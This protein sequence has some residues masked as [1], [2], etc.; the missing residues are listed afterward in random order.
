MSESFG[1]FFIANSQSG[2]QVGPNLALELDATLKTPALV[3]HKNF[4]HNDEKGYTSTK[5]STFQNLRPPLHYVRRNI[6]SKGKMNTL[7]AV[8]ESD[9]P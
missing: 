2:L 6:M 4:R 7:I 3:K 9:R 8:A 5:L 1:L